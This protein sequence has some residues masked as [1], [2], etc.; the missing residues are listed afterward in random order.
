VTKPKR[1]FG[2][3][4]NNIDNSISPLSIGFATY[5]GPVDVTQIEREVRPDKFA[6][7][8]VSRWPDYKIS[9][10]QRRARNTPSTSSSLFSVRDEAIFRPSM[11]EFEKLDNLRTPE[12]Q[13]KQIIR[14]VRITSRLSY[15]E[16]LSNRLEFLL[17][18]MKDEAEEWRKDS[19]ESLR[20]MLLFL[21][22]VPHFRYPPIT[23]T[24][25]AT[26]RI[27]WAAVRNRHFA[28]D[29]LP[30]GQV[31]FVVFCPDP[32]HS[33]RVQRLSGITSRENLIDVVKPYKVSDWASDAGK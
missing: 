3:S 26:F 27:Q 19:P 7:S 17:D 32:H 4:M 9:E 12:G 33:N 5:H 16:R 25:S 30:D 20:Q 13:I 10:L 14:R 21:G 24:P 23:I 2:A 15:R 22:T 18:A 29:F 11:G 6:T 28:A 31:K 1:N 8:E